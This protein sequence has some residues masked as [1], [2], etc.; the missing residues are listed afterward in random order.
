MKPVSLKILKHIAKYGEISLKEAVNLCSKKPDSHKEQYALALLISEEF[1]GMSVPFP[2][3]EG[4]EKMPE[5]M[6]ALFLHM[7]RLKKDENGNVIYEG[8]TQ[9]GA[10]FDKERVFIRAKGA[11]YLDELREKWKDRAISFL[12]GFFSALIPLLLASC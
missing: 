6:G 4:T 8:I 2:H 5:F 12:V 3:M 1:I 7:N 9:S 11:L 10:N